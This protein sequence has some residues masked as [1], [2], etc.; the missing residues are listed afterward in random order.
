MPPPDNPAT[1]PAAPTPAATAAAPAPATVLPAASGFDRTSLR[2][3]PGRALSGTRLYASYQLWLSPDFLLQAKNLPYSQEI[4]QFAYRDIQALEMC[5]TSR[6]LIYNLVLG[7]PL[8]IMLLVAAFADDSGT[9]VGWLIAAGVWL[10]PVVINLMRGPTCH[11]LL[12]TAL[13]PHALPSLSRRRPAR[14]A[15]A[16][17]AERVEAAQATK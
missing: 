8:L 7:L 10:L 13:G 1:I 3:L 11:C 15:L 14:R 12:Q 4:Q 9:R 16:M 5:A 6:W 17:I 2:R